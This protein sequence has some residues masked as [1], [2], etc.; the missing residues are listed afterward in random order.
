MNTINK[1]SG[2]SPNLKKIAIITTYLIFFADALSKIYYSAVVR[3]KEKGLADCLRDEYITRSI[4]FVEA[5]DRK[6]LVKLLAEAAKAFDSIIE[7]KEVLQVGIVGEIFIK[8]NH[9]G[10]QNV[11]NWFVQNG[12]EPVIPPLNE[13]FLQYFPN[14][15]YNESSNL[16]EKRNFKSRLLSLLGETLLNRI[17]KSIDKAASNYSYYSKMSNMNHEAEKASRIVNLAAQFGEG[18]L[19]PAEIASFAENGVN[20]VV[21]L[22]PFGCIANHVISKGIEKKIKDIY[23]DMNILYLDFDGG[24][25]EV[26]VLNRLHFIARSPAK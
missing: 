9:Y 23:P 11:V 17:I 26:N 7:R 14:A 8:Y 12:I 4:S 16:E 20:A 19:I 18:W 13:F 25:S 2:F 21:S 10:Q 5:R 3:E 1:Q 6:G 15:K 24:V 22:Q